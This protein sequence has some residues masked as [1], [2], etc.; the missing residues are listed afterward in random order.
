MHLTQIEPDTDMTAAKKHCRVCAEIITVE[1]RVKDSSRS[2]IYP[3]CRACHKE[4]VKNYMTGSDAKKKHAEVTSRWEKRNKEKRSAYTKV[5][6]ALKKG[7]MQKLPCIVCDN[8]VGVHAHHFDYSQPF[9]VVW[10][11]P[12]HHTIIHELKMTKFEFHKEFSDCHASPMD[13]C[14][15]CDLL[16]EKCEQEADEEKLRDSETLDTSS[17]G[18]VPD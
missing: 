7:E 1:T 18:V 16:Y 9:N 11:C 3:Y 13:G 15:I 8:E 4:M 5:R 17:K 10:L 14:E 2:S 12:K 6:I